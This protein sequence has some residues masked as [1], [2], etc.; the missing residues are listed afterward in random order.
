MASDGTRKS[1]QKH[2]AGIRYVSSSII[3]DPTT[4]TDLAATFLLLL[5]LLLS[6]FYFS[7][8]PIYYL[9]CLSPAIDGIPRSFIIRLRSLINKF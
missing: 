1:A 4:Y 9:D 7:R 6:S 5:L 2:H 8:T 3:L